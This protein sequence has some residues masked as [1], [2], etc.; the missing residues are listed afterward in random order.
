MSRNHSQRCALPTVL[1]LAVFT[2]LM[3]AA[4]TAVAAKKRLPNIVFFLVDDMSWTDPHCYG[5]KFHETPNIDRFARQ[6]MRFTNAYAACP[7]CS[8]TRASIISGKYPA[9]L[10]LTDFIPGHWR[11]YEKLIVPRMNLQLALQEISLAECVKPAGYVSGSFGKWHLGGRAF[12]PDKQG[13]D[14]WVVTSG[15]HFAPRF[16]TTPQTAVKKGEYLGDFLTRQAERFMEENRDKPFLLYLPHYAVHIPLEAKAA[17]VAKYEKK[18]QQPGYQRHVNVNI[19]RTGR[20]DVKLKNRDAVVSKILKGLAKLPVGKIIEEYSWGTPNRHF[21][22]IHLGLR[23]RTTLAGLEEFTKAAT[24]I[25][26]DILPK[27]LTADVRIAPVYHPTYAAM[28]EHID[29]SLGR[30]LKKLDELKLAENTVVIFFSDNGGLYRRFDEKGSAVMSNLPLRD[31]KGSLYEGGIREPCI[32]R[33]P[34]VVKPGSECPVPISSVDFWPTIAEIAGTSAKFTHKID[35]V[36]LL[37]LLKQ[38]G[39]FKDRAIYWHY[40]HYHHTSPAGAIRYGDFKLIEYF[41]DGRLELYNL[42]K[43]IG[44]TQNLAGND[45]KKTRQLQAMLKAWRKSVGAR[46]PAQNPNFDR[47]RRH[48]W[49]RRSRPKRKRAKTKR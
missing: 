9:T 47:K 45:P 36:S 3:T 41:D 20:T 38:T 37:P 14:D 16:R 12:Y 33:W 49:K 24:K 31:E 43:D 32:I 8:P 23:G 10:N 7:V 34:G 6:G 4:D 30:I 44:E 11:P 21:T 18:S 48:E 35:G 29:Q 2:T 46:M 42:A 22:R 25:V 1:L 15:R 5:N 19:R 27:G 39:S 40:P 13:F 17:L 28:V 26:N